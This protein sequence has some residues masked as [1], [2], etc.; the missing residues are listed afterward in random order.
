M[1]IQSFEAFMLTLP[2]TDA[3]TLKAKL[4]RGFADPSR[5]GILEALGDGPRTVTEVVE[6]TGLSQPNVSS[7][8]ACLHDCGLVSREQVGR[9]VRYRLSDPRV[10]AFLDEA[11][12]LLADLARGV[13]ECTRYSRPSEG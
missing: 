8:L 12:A 9:Y 7:H 6:A 13:Y 10:A 11:D 3:V 1:L 4:F 5:L 2:Q